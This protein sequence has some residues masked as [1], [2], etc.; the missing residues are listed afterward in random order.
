M[1]ATKLTKGTEMNACLDKVSIPE[2]PELEFEDKTHT[3]TLDGIVIPSVSEIMEPLSKEKYK[4]I[5][6]STLNKAAEKGTAVHNSIENYIKF[7]IDDVPPEHRGYFDAFLD[8]CKLYKPDVVE[9][10]LKIYHKLLKYGGT[11]DILAYI[12]GVLT[13]IDIKTTSV[14]SDMTCGVQL[15]AY[16]QALKSLGIAV[17]RKL[18]LQLKKTRKYVIREYPTMDTERWRVFGSLKCVYDYIKKSA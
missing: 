10:E 11:I 4:G 13:L 14:L 1:E 9:S 3:Y 12:D 6:E 18:I 7:E 16:T 5:S 8:W 17:E 2:L 15:E